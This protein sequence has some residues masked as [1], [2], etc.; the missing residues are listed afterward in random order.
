MA[1]LGA[2]VAG[3]N[4]TIDK[5]GRTY[6]LRTDDGREVGDFR[7]HWSL[8][9]GSLH[10][11]ERSWDIHATDR[12]HCG[13]IVGP[14][15]DPL[16][17]L[18]PDQSVL[19]SGPATWQLTRRRGRYRAILRRGNDVLSLQLRH[20]HVDIEATGP[21]APVEVLAAGFAI[22]ARRRHDRLAAA[23]VAVAISHPH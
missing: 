22:L 1:G 18:H 7:G 5:S 9:G 14:D 20:G 19:P 17:R 11:G 16:V 21:W 2:I 8:F 3:M 13:M 10:A 6:H 15:A 12:G 23:A 4:L